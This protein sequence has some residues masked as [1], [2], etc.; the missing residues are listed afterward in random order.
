MMFKFASIAM[1]A[2]TAMFLSAGQVNAIADNDVDACNGSNDYE[3]GH[4]CAFAESQGTCQT[5]ACG[6]LICIPN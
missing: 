5:N 4:S 6:N 1:I 2:L 3:V